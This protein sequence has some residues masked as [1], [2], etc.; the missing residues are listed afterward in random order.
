MSIFYR[1]AVLMVRFH[2]LWAETAPPNVMSF[3]P[4]HEQ[5]LR[6][7]RAELAAG[8]FTLSHTW[9]DDGAATSAAVKSPKNV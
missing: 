9:F 3:Q 1:P 6:T 2:Q 4:I 8:T 5:F 7:V